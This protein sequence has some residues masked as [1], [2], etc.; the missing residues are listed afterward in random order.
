MDTAT[1]TRDFWH[2]RVQ[3]LKFRS[4]HF[5]DGAYVPSADGRTFSTV[6]PANGQELAQVA[7]GGTAETMLTYVLLGDPAL[8][9]RAPGEPPASDSEGTR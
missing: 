4:N 8:T 1:Y 2:G 3:S 7:R 6:N 9:L 5:I